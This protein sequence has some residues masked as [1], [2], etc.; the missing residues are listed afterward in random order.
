MKE[1]I[2]LF[3]FRLEKSFLLTV[4][5]H[6]L[7]M[8]IPFILA[9]GIASAIA[10]FPLPSY[11][12]LI[13]GTVFL[14]FFNTIYEGTFGI[15]SILL[16]IS[17]CASFCLEL[18]MSID[19]IIIYIL[20]GLGS[21]GVQLYV[22]GAEFNYDIIGIKGC[23]F[24]IVTALLSCKILNL[25]QKF[26]LLNLR[27]HTFGMER[28]TALAISMFIPALIVISI[29][30]LV[31]NL[32]LYIFNVPSLYSLISSGMNSLFSGIR[33]EFGKGFLFTFL[34]H[35]MWIF[36]LHGSH[37]LEPVS[38]ANLTADIDNPIFTQSFFNIYIIMGGCGTTICALLVL[39][40]FFRKTRFNKLAKFASV[41]VIFNINEL[42][43][44]GIPIILNPIL[45]LPF[46]LTPLVCFVIAFFA[47]YSGL[48]PPAST[49]V[50]WSTPILFSGYMATNSIRGLILQVVL[51]IVGMCIY[52]PFIRMNLRAQS[53]YA[54]EQLVDVVKIL[55]EKEELNEPVNL[56]TMS[57][58]E[59]QITRMLKHDISRAIER[60]ELYLLFQPQLDNTGK[61][62]GAEALL[63]WEHPLYGFIYPP[64]IIYLAK[65]GGILEKLEREII[66]KTVSSIADIKKEF[67]SDFKISMNLTAKSLLWDIEKYI[68]EK[69]SQYNVEPKQL[70][71]EITEQDVLLKASIVINKLESLKEK[72][73]IMMID[74]FGMGHT[75][76]L[77]LQSQHFGVVKL[78]GSLV[79]NVL[80]NPTNQQIISSI[81][82]LGDKLDV[83][84]IAEYVETEAQ[85]DKLLEL[86]C[87]W[88][89]GYMYSKPIPLSDFIDYLKSHQPD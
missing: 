32:I 50:S 80:T 89:Q 71:F 54:K 29:F 38:G 64:L 55:Q 74:D 68:D 82:S 56:L 40:L 63:R 5:R 11:Q 78:D 6:G 88:Y 36:G 25:L 67:G 18:N 53:R 21:F 4:I 59:G 17:L 69:L 76:I 39:L 1:K 87:K 37:I 77:Y 44:F 83:K 22:P 7:A 28:I 3:T 45:A 8:L 46:L 79:R 23:F 52:Y 24:A 9:G 72:G 75:S 51:I 43:T 41:T 20:V 30:A 27:N 73:H 62:I 10:N 12:T 16:V 81:V 15:F 26:S 42:L 70:W 84:V 86:G 35:I 66:D 61:C 58:R 2:K 33:S 47:T 85:R 48:V 13:D 19:K 49:Y 65:E 60:D 14:H 34:L 31:T 57:S